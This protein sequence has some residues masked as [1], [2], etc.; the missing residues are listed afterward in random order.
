MLCVIISAI[1]M[2]A[3]RGSNTDPDGLAGSEVAEIQRGSTTGNEENIDSRSEA[4]HQA[5]PESRAEAQE[6]LSRAR[7]ALAEGNYELAEEL[8][9][10]SVQ[11]E[12]MTVRESRGG[13]GA[14]EETHDQARERALPVLKE[15]WS[16]YREIREKR[17]TAAL[18]WLEPEG[19]DPD[20]P[21][22]DEPEPDGPMHDEPERDGSDPDEPVR[23]G[24]THADAGPVQ[25]CPCR[26]NPGLPC[27][28][29]G[30]TWCEMNAM[31][32]R[33]EGMFWRQLWSCF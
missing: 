3:N 25:G 24:P 7:R 31:Y 11:Q 6:I 29:G 32:D 9:Y 2:I 22:H 21:I 18:P 13:E 5:N 20:E 28:C 26:E 16:V 4:E 12:L 17:E 8:A 33:D 30:I 1:A 27:T 14:V 19:P 23:D 15:M 10:N